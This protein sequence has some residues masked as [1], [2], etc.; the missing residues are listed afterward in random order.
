MKSIGILAVA[1][2]SCLLLPTAS[3]ADNISE[4]TQSV[5]QSSTIVGSGN[6]VITD[7]QQSSIG[8]Q[9]SRRHSDNRAVNSQRI[10][11]KTIV[12]GDR[13]IDVKRI[14]QEAL[15]GHQ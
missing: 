5:M 12:V 6:L 11:A 9:Q 1:L 7:T 14:V 10:N 15:A 13:N 4:N 8:I 2:G 3:F